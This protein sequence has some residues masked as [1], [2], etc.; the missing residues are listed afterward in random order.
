MGSL[1]MVFLGGCI[2]APADE[3]AE[4]ATAAVAEEVSAVPPEQP[5][6]DEGEGSSLDRHVRPGAKGMNPA[7]TEHDGEDNKPQPD[8]WSGAHVQRTNDPVTSR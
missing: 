8:P 1:A 7:I 6:E 4:E 3:E 5:P 2:M